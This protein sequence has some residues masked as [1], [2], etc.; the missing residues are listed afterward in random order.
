MAKNISG[1]FLNSLFEYES[2]ACRVEKDIENVAPGQPPRTTLKLLALQNSP[3]RFSYAP[4]KGLIQSGP[5]GGVL[6][7]NILGKL[8]AIPDDDIDAHVAFF[9][10]Y[11][12]LYPVSATEYEAVDADTLME[13]VNRIKAT[14]TLMNAIAGKKNYKNI[15]M[16]TAYLLYAEPITLQLSTGEYST[17][18]HAFTNLV[19]SYTQFPDMSRNKEVFNTKKFSVPDTLYPP[20]YPVDI[21][22]FNHVRSLAY[23]G[24]LRCYKNLVAMYTGLT[25][26]GPDLRTIIDFFF[27]YQEEVGIFTDI[28]YNKI[29][30]ESK[31]QPD[32]FSEAMKAALLSIAKIVLREEINY[33]I[34]GI[35]PRYSSTDLAPTW[36]LD[37]LVQA[38]YFSIF[39]MKPGVQIYKRCKNPTCKRDVYF[40][41]NATATNKEYCCPAC[42]NAAAQRRSRERKLSGG[43]LR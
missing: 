29:R 35:H 12:F 27:H 30:Y 37:N 18:T 31:I 13:F 1:F 41:V 19:Y 2:Q 38:L 34:A 5:A 8:L 24:H 4:Q 36:K 21:E 28:A 39:Y 9:M 17:C 40:L 14:V 26:V 23:T 11:G 6:A 22:H 43:S 42:A 32:S 7:D 10:E 15:L 3:I 25:D 33:N 20:N 16:E